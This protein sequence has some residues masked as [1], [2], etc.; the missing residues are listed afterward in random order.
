MG[1]PIAGYRLQRQKGS[2]PPRVRTGL[3]GSCH[4][5]TLPSLNLE[6][7][8]GSGT[9][10][11]QR[12]V[13]LRGEPAYVSSTKLNRTQEDLLLHCRMASGSAEYV[14]SSAPAAEKYAVQK[15]FITSHDFGVSPEGDAP[16]T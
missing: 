3:S 8:L 5:G 9:Q 16:T 6:E 4:K 10:T 2:P 7:S 11:V 15:P 12:L 1:N 13:L 14:T